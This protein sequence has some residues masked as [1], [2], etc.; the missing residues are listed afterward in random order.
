MSI[1]A[2]TPAAESRDPYAEYG[3]SGFTKRSDVDFDD[4]RTAALDNLDSIIRH[5]LPNGRQRGDEWFALNPTRNDKKA[6]SFSVNTKTGL[7]HDFSTKE[8]GD[9]I[10]LW[11]CVKRLN[12]DEDAMYELNDFLGVKANRSTG[13][14]RASSEGLDLNNADPQP[15]SLSSKKASTDR[16]ATGTA[17]PA[18][19][20]IAPQTFPPHTPPDEEGKPKLIVAGDGGPR[21]WSNEKR[22]HIY[23]QGGVPVHIKI[24]M[25]DGDALSAYQ[26]FNE[27]DS[28]TGWQY[29]RP[30]GFKNVPYFVAGANP[31]DTKTEPIY[32]PEG[33]KDVETIARL[34]GLAFTFGGTGDGLP[35][36]C[37]RYVARRHVVILADND[38]AGRKHAE[39]KAALAATVAA[40]VK[41]IHFLE[42]AEHGDVSDWIEAG[43]TFADLK[44]HVE[45]GEVWQVKSTEQ[46]TADDSS[47]DQSGKPHPIEIFW[48]GKKYDRAARPALVKDLIP[49]VGQGL[50]S[51]QWGAAKTFAVIDLSASVMTGT[52]FAGR[53][54]CRRG[55]VLFVAAEGASEIP[56]R[57]QGVVDHK[58]R[59]DPSVAGAVNLDNLPFAWIEECPSLKEDA[60]FE[61]LVA[62]VLAAAA[63]MQEQFNVDLVLIVIDTL[64]ASAD[65]TDQNDAAEGQR[66]MNRLNALSR[67]TGAFTLAVD[68]FGKAMETGTRGTSAK[69]AA[70]DVVLALLADR[71]VSGTIS[72]TRLAVRKLRGGATGTETPFD[73]KVVDIGDGETTCIIE[74]RSDRTSRSTPT[75]TKESKATKMFR[76]SMNSAMASANGKTIRP[77]G[78]EG[79]AVRAVALHAV[80]DEFVAAWPADG[81]TPAKV[82]DAKRSAFNRALKAL[83]DRDIC[84]REIG[85]IDYLWFVSEPEKSTA[86]TD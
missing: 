71:D 85:G 35:D 50:A 68:H 17:T 75:T 62:I 10:H 19:A 30:E 4:V 37:E 52:P 32:W 40:N 49:E 48:H 28:T 72:N 41:V 64:S 54:V 61:R 3:A 27:A 73:L 21:T 11:A 20:S 33:E 18:E 82:A 12:S 81:D 26:V 31:F 9:V 1:H 8:G 45:A 51:G 65:F 70:A 22:R 76:S 5:L 63:Q 53:E 80:R 55:G 38:D 16:P 57:L 39:E 14:C 43:H 69:E 58:L 46:P 34:G 56:I 36:R 77:F 66:I 6:G 42:L 44:A 23:R 79:A 78:A 84:S 59:P 2:Q 86:A 13:S 24:M 67:R 60:S 83:R 29:R 15:E 47:K 74:W 7:W 25:K